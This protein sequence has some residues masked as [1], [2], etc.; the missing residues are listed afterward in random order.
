MRRWTLVTS[1][2]LGLLPLLDASARA[3]EVSTPRAAVKLDAQDPATVDYTAWRVNALAE[4]GARPQRNEMQERALIA[5]AKQ[6]WRSAQPMA[7][8][9]TLLEVLR[10]NP[11]NI[12]AH[13]LL[14]Y[15]YEELSQRTQEASYRTRL[16]ALADRHRAFTEGLVRSILTS[17][18]GQSPDSAYQVISVT[19]EYMVLLALGYTRRGQRLLEADGKVYDVLD[20][21]NRDGQARTFYFDISRFAFR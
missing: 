19:E 9:T 7:A 11:V 14:A 15:M 18:D 4:A 5:N 2:L 13:M 20:A 21:R 8:T 17:G 12:H 10:R 6:L 16:S 3:Q 1:V